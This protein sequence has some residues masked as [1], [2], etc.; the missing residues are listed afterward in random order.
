MTQ[1]ARILTGNYP[2]DDD[3]VEIIEERPLE[4][5]S[6]EV[7]LNIAYEYREKYTAAENRAS[8]L[9]AELNAKEFRV[10]DLE[11]KLTEAKAKLRDPD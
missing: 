1:S 10:Q 8:L 3:S 6:H 9:Q 2:G 11:N 7:L 5:Y 4:S